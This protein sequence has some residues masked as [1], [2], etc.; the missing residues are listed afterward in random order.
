MD[1]KTSKKRGT[2]IVIPVILAIL[3][4][5]IVISYAIRTS[6]SSDNVRDMLIESCISSQTSTLKTFF[7]RSKK[8]ISATRDKVET[9]LDE[10]RDTAIKQVL[11]DSFVLLNCDYLGYINSGTIVFSTYGFPDFSE[12]DLALLNS[13]AVYSLDRNELSIMASKRF[14]YM[15]MPCFRDGVPCGSLFN[16]FDR[17]HLDSIIDSAIFPD[18]YNMLVDSTGKVVIRAT[19][20]FYTKDCDNIY[21]IAHEVNF[22][23]GYSEQQIRDDITRQQKSCFSFST[24]GVTYYSFAAA[25][26]FDDL[27]LVRTFTQDKI[28]QRFDKETRDVFLYGVI[29][30]ILGGLIIVMILIREREYRDVMNR[31]ADELRTSQRLLELQEKEYNIA[32]NRKGSALLTLDLSSKILV[33]P[34]NK[35]EEFAIPTIY[36]NVPDSLIQA[37]LFSTDSIGPVI[38]ACKK[39]YSGELPNDITVETDFPNNQKLWLG[40]SFDF[41]MNFKGTPAKLLIVVTDVTARREA[42]AALNRFESSILALDPAKFVSIEYNISRNRLIKVRGSLFDTSIITYLDDYD[43]FFRFFNDN[44]LSQNE[45]E[46]IQRFSTRESLTLAFS[47]GMTSA[48]SD[49]NIVVE[50]E[51]V[52]VRISAKMVEY[53]DSGDI[54]LFLMFE[55]LNDE[56]AEKLKLR[57]LSEEDPLTGILNRRAFEHNFNRLISRPGSN[58]HHTLIILDLDGFKQIND[59]FGHQAG[60]N[61]LIETAAT[62]RSHLRRSDFIGRLG[63]DEFIICLTNTPYESVILKKLQQLTACVKRTYEGGISITGSF[64]ASVFPNDGTTFEELYQSADAA[65][66]RAKNL[67]KCCFVL[68]DSEFSGSDDTADKPVDAEVRSSKKR[69]LIATPDSSESAHFASIFESTYAVL[70]TNEGQSTL[71]LMLQ[72]GRNTDLVILSSDFSDISTLELLRQI[73]INIELNGIPII[74]LDKSGDP[75]F[76]VNAMKNGAHKVITMPVTDN[77]LVLQV[78]ST[79]IQLE[80]DELRIQ[81]RYFLMQNDE[82][83]RY[84]HI[85]VTTGTL[86]FEH[87]LITDEYMYDPLVSEHLL[88]NYNSRPLLTI[89]KDDL[90]ADQEDIDKIRTLLDDYKL[91]PSNVKSVST[92]VCLTTSANEKRWFKFSAM[93]LRDAS[94]TEIVR[95]LIYTL[96]DIHDRVLTDKQ[97]KYM[98]EY[99][100]LTGIL[101]RAS[102]L[103]RSKE[104][105]RNGSSGE[106]AMIYFDISRFKVVNDI[107]GHKEGDRLLKTVASCLNGMD[108]DNT[109]FGRMSSDHFGAVIP[110]LLDSLTGFMNTLDAAIKKYSLSVD[111]SMKYGIYVIDSTDTAIDIILD[112]AA[113]AHESV[114]G[115]FLTNY[116]Y[117]DAELRN[118][119]IEEQNIVNNMSSALERNEFVVFYQPLYNYGDNAIVGAEA[120]VRWDHPNNGLMLPG[121]FIPILEQNGFMLKLDMYVWDKVC[122]QIRSWL[123]EGI[124]PVPISVNVS[125]VDVY[126]KG[127]CD[128]IDTLVRKYSIPKDLIRFEITEGAYVNSQTQILDFSAKLK[129]NGYMIE[130][131]DFGTGFSSLNVLHDISVDTLKL[132]MKHLYDSNKSYSKSRNLISNIISIADTLN[133]HVVAE[134]VESQNQADELANLGCS[135]MQGYHYSK[136]V[137]SDTFTGYLQR[138]S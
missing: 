14:L 43:S 57:Y 93:K 110:A 81:N 21:N 85:L 49:F 18:A 132:N 98:A 38:D 24:G 112:R 138:R 8:C 105:I 67:G 30:L 75:E 48:E 70:T 61:T 54:K 52:P 106:F 62:L 77:A 56:T 9:V 102:F 72:F 39:V 45:I 6:R 109:C 104:M 3:T 123:D 121:S 11:D 23:P 136:P 16:I 119:V 131:D 86:V 83:A 95:K 73:S 122:S 129:S 35:A 137:S 116:A 63:G 113:L 88:G 27:Y 66:Y 114:K 100:D 46:D 120:L 126:Y 31:E 89:F 64:G 37:G 90:V 34:Q 29:V 15:F 22:E 76:S 133:M 96:T 97:L 36:D 91:S 44:M 107:F 4:L 115:T 10:N 87:N 28:S 32:F 50:E 101:N 125:K 5:T 117:Y 94:N 84:R 127:L 99:D 17:T 68:A 111:L 1:I 2:T 55:R 135:T 78:Q 53:S 20:S 134:G 58:E 74:V 103:A 130:M 82:E 60:D 71:R 128:T 118:S 108:L 65:L 51:T 124:R 33:I 41:V 12:D 80:N 40:L 59:T 47:H 13:D 69:L 7:D 79:F 19:E 92:D 25:I 26:G 42:E